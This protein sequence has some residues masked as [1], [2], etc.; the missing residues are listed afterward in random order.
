MLSSQ[1]GILVVILII[2]CESKPVQID[3]GDSGHEL[4]VFSTDSIQFQSIQLP[5]R[6]GTSSKLYLGNIN[7]K[8]SSIIFKLNADVFSQHELCT[9]DLDSLS[10]SFKIKLINENEVAEIPLENLE[11]SVLNTITF[12]ENPI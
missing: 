6:I 4:K 10:F 3:L 2:G 7:G 9:N 8:K 1:L 5:N 11:D 12:A